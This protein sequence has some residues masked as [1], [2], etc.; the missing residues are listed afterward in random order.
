[1]AIRTLKYEIGDEMGIQAKAEKLDSALVIKYLDDNMA[2]DEQLILKCGRS[3]WDVTKVP[4]FFYH[5][6]SEEFNPDELTSIDKR[7]LSETPAPKQAFQAE[8]VQPKEDPMSLLFRKT[9]NDQKTEKA[10]LLRKTYYLRPK[11]VEALTILCHF[12]RVEVSAM[13]REVFERG[14]TSIANEI[15]YGDLYGEAEENLANGIL[16]KKKSFRR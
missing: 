12:T 15:E 4:E 3:F 1:M 13:V 10:E 6:A 16:G 2:Q 9:E 11:D 7:Q 8:P 5:E 14:L